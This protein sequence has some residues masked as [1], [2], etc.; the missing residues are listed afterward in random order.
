MPFDLE[1]PELDASGF[2]YPIEYVRKHFPEGL[3]SFLE[4]SGHDESYWGRKRGSHRDYLQLVHAFYEVVGYNPSELVAAYK[5]IGE[6]PKNSV[7]RLAR[8][9][10]S[11][12]GVLRITARLSPMLN[13]DSQIRVPF[14]EKNNGHGKAFVEQTVLGDMNLLYP[15]QILGGVGYYLGF[16]PLFHLSERVEATMEMYQCKLRDM[17]RRYH[18]SFTEDKMGNILDEEGNILAFSTRYSE[19]PMGSWKPSSP[20]FIHEDGRMFAGNPRTLA[21]SDVHAA[22]IENLEVLVGQR[23][24]LLGDFPLVQEGVVYGGKDFAPSSVYTLRW[25]DKRGFIS[26]SIWAISDGIKNIKNVTGGSSA[27]QSMTLLA[28]REAENRAAAE[29][30]LEDALADLDKRTLEESVRIASESADKDNAAQEIHG[31]IHRINDAGLFSRS[32]AF[33]LWVNSYLERI[34]SFCPE[35]KER[36]SEDLLVYNQISYPDALHQSKKGVPLDLDKIGTIGTSLKEILED[37]RI[38]QEVREEAFDYIHLFDKAGARF[39]ITEKYFRGLMEGRRASWVEAKL[40]EFFSSSMKNF[41]AKAAGTKLEMSIS[42][43]LSVEGLETQ[44]HLLCDNL[45]VNALDAGKGGYARFLGTLEDGVKLLTI[46]NSAHFTDEEQA[47][48]I[49][50]KMVNPKRGFSTRVNAVG[51]GGAGQRLIVDS[52]H[53]FNAQYFVTPLGTEAVR[54]KIIFR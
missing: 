12:L 39:D 6:D 15:E 50:A 48:E 38:P 10:G 27:L 25:E 49:C 2:K 24:L 52:L 1:G 13:K 29:R 35:A 23:D 41:S 21:L 7:G 45:L 19:S 8:L 43:E 33:M 54:Q 3:E 53:L 20:I 5:A 22:S 40:A 47:R 42:P 17:L 36:V 28:D 32:T 31:G 4:K 11:P 14:A 51:K 9:T 34:S 18:V 44:L 16:E 37:G 26:N 46:E 30:S